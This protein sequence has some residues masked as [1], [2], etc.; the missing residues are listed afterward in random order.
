MYILCFYA[1]FIY[2][3]IQ[4]LLS[5]L[6]KN[7]I[8]DLEVI[9]E[10]YIPCAGVTLI[11]LIPLKSVS[12]PTRW[13]FDGR[14]IAYNDAGN[15]TIYNNE[16]DKKK[17]VDNGGGY[18]CW[19]NQQNI[20]V[21]RSVG[22]IIFYDV[23]NET[24][25]F[26]IIDRWE[27]VGG[28]S[29][30]SNSSF[31]CYSV[32]QRGETKLEVID[33]ENKRH[34]QTI[35]TKN[36]AVQTI[37][38]KDDK[39]LIVQYEG[40]RNVNGAQGIAV[41]DTKTWNLLQTI[42]AHNDSLIALANNKVAYQ[43]AGNF[44]IFNLLTGKVEETI[45]AHN[46]NINAMCYSADGDFFVTKS[47]DQTVKVWRCRD[48]EMVAR[49]KESV[50][51][52]IHHLQLEI[53]FCPV[54]PYL[55]TRANIDKDLRIWEIDF[56]YL[57]KKPGKNAIK[58]TSA[59]IVL[60]GDT[61][62]G[63]TGLGWR[64]AKSDY[65]EHDSTHGQQFWIVDE[66]GVTRD[67]G[68]N[69][70]A[71]L[72][73]LAGQTDYRL[74]HALFLD[75]ANLAIIVFDPTNRNELLNA[76]L[77]WV[78]QLRKNNEDCCS[79]ILV[80]ARCDRGSSTLTQ[81]ELDAF[82]K[83]N[84]IAGG[85]FLTSAKSDVGIEDLISQIKA[86]I[87]WDNLN[88]TITNSTFKKVKD[89]ILALKE[90]TDRREIL[91]TPTELRRE[92]ELSEKDW[93]FSDDEMMAAA[94]NLEIHGY[95]KILRDSKGGVHILLRPDMLTNLASSYV[96]EAR[97]NVR[98]LGVLEE[99]KLLK[100]GYNFP[101]LATITD[102]EKE[103]LLE[104]TTVLFLEH[105]ICFRENFNSEA[106]LVFPSL[107]N[108]KK[109]IIDEIAVKEDIF[110]KIKGPVENVYASMVVL[111]GYTNV[112]T[113]NNQWQNQ[114]QYQ[115]SEGGICGFKQTINLDQEIELALYY[116][117]DVSKSVKSLFQGLFERFLS[118]KDLSVYRYSPVA[119]ECGEVLERNYISS[120]LSKGR[121]F[122]FCTSC[123]TKL[124]LP[125]YE[126]INRET[127]KNER[128]SEQE[129][130]AL[131]RATYES[132]VVKI[133]GLA[134]DNTAKPKCFICY[135]WGDM[136]Q[137]EWV[138]RFA[139]DLRNS[140]VDVLLDRWH[141]SPG[142][143]ISEY[144]DQIHKSAFIIVIGTSLL[145]E[146]YDDKNRDAVVTAELSLINTRLLRP[147]QYGLNVIPI[148]LEGEQKSSFIPSL[149][150]IV[151]IDCRNEENYFYNIFSLIWRLY[152]LPF[153]NPN[154]SE[155]LSMLKSQ[156]QKRNAK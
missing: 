17:I 52:A 40:I 113:R 92:L 115:V 117:K 57:R 126:E 93:Q 147:S 20:I 134:K 43:S 14:F 84:G 78:N 4:Y 28:F 2:I 138:L 66:L 127:N 99:G 89:F 123:G 107:I 143:R 18:Y 30:S 3:A 25:V 50:P 114:A 51:Q 42:P 87:P 135:A 102:R 110:Y 48:W 108:E 72:W 10:G 151:Y 148:L 70:E 101:E 132:V 19:C 26:E 11:K 44:S 73:D 97:R 16:N 139:R 1:I 136:A 35:T 124:N 152:E 36:F 53:G 76:P 140:D 21:Y 83:Q 98:G 59:K 74:V 125:N 13:S 118:G 64:I 109:P 88:I 105:A 141:N 62:V 56:D 149:Q 137:E 122:A 15:I 8:E 133:K 154:Y 67:D 7:T 27:E 116:S 37:W 103:V 86:Q 75:S 94:R 121:N 68:T 29:F 31:F 47:L 91:F 34:I 41:W 23:E 131:R 145:R 100:G 155:T 129:E 38:G 65:K 9:T 49:F 130:I 58:Y 156:G 119:C 85:Y 120:Q 45:E 142:T 24:S 112:F 128:L 60:V 39:C 32:K 79:M 6:T 33:W 71:V 90:N 46:E 81:Y 150:D 69:C 144:T 63:K 55:I 54:A 96:L 22:R 80:G 77:F 153:D 104:A 111:L 106:L 12:W 146:K 5:M 95:V 61:G 82:C